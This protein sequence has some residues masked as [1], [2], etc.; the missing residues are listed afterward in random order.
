MKNKVAILRE[1]RTGALP[2]TLQ[3][4][5]NFPFL[6][7]GSAIN[8][9][10][11]MRTDTFIKFKQGEIA[12]HADSGEPYIYLASAKVSCSRPEDRHESSFLPFL[13]SDS[14]LS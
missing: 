2:K 13:S 6:F 3:E 7:I 14:L 8:S 9:V 4:C 10:M 5:N 1:L 12:V 11:V